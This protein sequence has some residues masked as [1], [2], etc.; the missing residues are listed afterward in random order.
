MP[1]DPKEVQP[2]QGAL[3]VANPETGDFAVRDLG[4]DLAV[5]L[6]ERRLHLLNVLSLF[7][8]INQ[9]ENFYSYQETAA[10]YRYKDRAK[11]VLEGSRGNRDAMVAEAKQ[12]FG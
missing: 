5:N 4:E 2:G 9:R 7:S 10:Q 6:E 8:A 11:Q 3:I 12:E 1:R